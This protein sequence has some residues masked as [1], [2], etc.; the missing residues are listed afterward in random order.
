LEKNFD[1]DAELAK[2]GGKLQEFNTGT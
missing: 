2:F 1:H